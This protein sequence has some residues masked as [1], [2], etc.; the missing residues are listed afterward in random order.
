MK[1]NSGEKLEISKKEEARNYAEFLAEIQNLLQQGQQEIIDTLT[2]QK[3]VTSWQIGK[4]INLYLQKN[5]RAG[6]GDEL[7]NQ[8]AQDTAISRTVLYHMRSFYQAYPQ[9]PADDDK[10]NWSHYRALSGIK[11]EDQRQYFAQLAQEKNFDVRTLESEIKKEV[12]YDKVPAL[13]S[14]KVAQKKVKNAAAVP[15]K[16]TAKRGKLFSYKV[17]SLGSDSASYFDCGFK[18]FTKVESA[19]GKKSNLSGIV[20][21]VKKDAEYSVKK[22]ANKSSLIHTYK[23]EIEKVVDGDTLNVILDLGFD[24]KHREIVRLAQINAAEIG[25]AEGKIAS[26]ALKKILRGVPFVIVKTIQT[27]IYGRYIADVFF[28]AEKAVNADPQQVADEGIYLNQ[29]L[30]EQGL[31]KV[32]NND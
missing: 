1:D 12:N 30:V 6:Y 17:A 16:I 27:D 20:D 23:A 8:L 25:T 29:L 21:V 5:N 14:G 10:L 31:V 13:K 32:F 26:D 7:I 11:S 3:V 28:D 4:A 24:I 2:R 19:L 22:S 15:T 9:L 18:V